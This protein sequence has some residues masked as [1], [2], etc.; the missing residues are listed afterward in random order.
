[1][2]GGNLNVEWRKGE[3]GRASA[4]SREERWEE[5]EEREKKCR[6]GG[7]IIMIVW[8]LFAHKWVDVRNYKSNPLAKV[9][10]VC[11]QGQ[12]GNLASNLWVSGVVIDSLALWLNRREFACKV[13]HVIW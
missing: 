5:G 13:I 10:Q 6:N 8:F 1:M 4:K 3:G 9:R 11:M 2:G 12:G 7:V